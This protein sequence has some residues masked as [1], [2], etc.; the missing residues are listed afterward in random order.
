M[1][2]LVGADLLSTDAVFMVQSRELRWIE[3]AIREAAVEQSAPLKKCLACPQHERILAC[4][5]GD[6][7]LVKAVVAFGFGLKAA[8]G[9]KG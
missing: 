2:V 8:A 4:K 5:E 1:R 6:V 3:P 7:L 9:A